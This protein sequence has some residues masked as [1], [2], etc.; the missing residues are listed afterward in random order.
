MLISHKWLQTFFDERIP[1]AE[2]ISE[3][4]IFHAF[5]VEEVE[6]AGDDFVLDIDVLP[7]RGHDALCHRGIAKDISAIF[8]IPLK[9]DPLSG[10][11]LLSPEF[12]S[13]EVSIENSDKCHRFTGAVI[14]GVEVKESPAWLKESLEAIGQKSINN[15]VDAT[16]YIMFSIGQPLHA[17]DM[18]KLHKEND[19]VAIHVRNAIG[20]EVIKTL[21]GGEHKL[22]SN[23]QVISDKNSGLAIAIAGIKGGHSTEVDKN[24][25]NVIIEAASFDSVTTR[26]ASR[27][28][29]LNTDASKR[30]ENI[31]S[32]R[33][34]AYAQKVITKLILDIAGGTL[35]GYVDEYPKKEE[36][37]VVSFTSNDVNSLLGS[38]IDDSETEDIL[39]RLAFSYEKKGDEYVVSP[40]FER[41][42]IRIK[43]DL[44][45]EVGRI[46]GYENILEIAPD[47]AGAVEVNKSYY[48]AEVIRDILSKEGFVEVYSR[49]LRSSGEVALENALASD[50]DHLRV[51]LAEGVEEALIS[52]EKN[53]PLLG[54]GVMKIFE[55]GN[56][57][58]KEDEHTSVCLGVN[59]GKEIKDTISKI[60][61][62]LGVNIKGESTD[63]TFEFNLTELLK[64]L[65]EV[66]SYE[67]LPVVSEASYKTFSLY[68]FVLRDIAV[69]VP[70]EIKESDLLSLIKDTAGGLL[71]QSMI[72]DRFEKDE[73][74]SYAFRLVFQSQERTLTDEEINKVMDVVA[75]TLSSKEGYEVR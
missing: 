70:R 56:I 37:V 46:Y 72:F 33:L 30:F 16:N 15:I 26:L 21:D 73:R 17:F 49:S 68:P 63:K 10:E 31:L 3:K 67:K 59:V 23:V 55:I 27:E 12:N 1:S 54:M 29:K 8:N 48:Y 57:F 25:K 74:V 64:E 38:S 18:D 32:S 40:P 2:V 41:L 44:I 66:S 62:V 11:A 24:T 45:E 69:W 58:T 13:L 52:N 5:E 34:P 7:N 6:S 43:E 65:P 51:N 9:G 39:R 19:G 42:D 22:S 36:S 14:K 61:G 4:L 75:S 50:K 28:L 20:G 35:D 47:K 71:V 53:L 60:G